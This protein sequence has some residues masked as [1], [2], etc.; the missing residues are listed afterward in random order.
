MLLIGT[1][2]TSNWYLVSIYILSS[3]SVGIDLE[4]IEISYACY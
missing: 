2:L 3:T 1:T 4:I